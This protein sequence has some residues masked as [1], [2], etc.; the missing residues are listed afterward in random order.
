MTDQSDFVGCA[1]FLIIG[2]RMNRPDALPLGPSSYYAPV[3]ALVVDARG[4]ITDFNVALRVLMHPDIAGARLRSVDDLSA[5]IRIAPK[6]TYSHRIDGLVLA[7][8]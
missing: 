3:P 7:R 6:A 8:V 1:E 4:R 2:F 5:E